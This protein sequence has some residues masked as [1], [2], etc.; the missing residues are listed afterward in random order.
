M[1]SPLLEIE[2]VRVYFT[3][4]ASCVRAVDGVDLSV[5]EGEVLGLVGESGCGK[6]TL[7]RAVMRLVP[8][9]A[10]RI[11][12]EGV[13]LAGLPR[14]LLNGIRPRLQ[15][16]FQDPY[17]SLNPRMTVF[18]TIAEPLRV[19]GRVAR[20]DTAGRVV[21]LMEQVGLAGRFARKYPH[22]FSGGQRQRIAIARALALDPRLIIADEPVS[23]LDVSVQAQILNLLSD[24]IRARGLALILVSHDLAVVRHL[25]H[26]VAVMKEG[27]IIE[28]GPA[29]DVFDRPRH[30]HTRTLLDATPAMDP[31][32]ARASLLK[33]I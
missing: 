26:R 24:L 25:A 17:S 28:I 15:M 31:A 5:A 7:A 27:R 1:T 14:R 21:R 10:G 16:I 12:F 2:E 22:E 4:G 30:A 13:D 20:R 29:G 33:N 32:K 18:D 23:A 19:H 6:T 8:L 3:K 11:R 9:T